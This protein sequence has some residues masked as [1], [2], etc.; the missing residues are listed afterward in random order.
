MKKKVEKP[1]FIPTKAISKSSDG[2]CEDLPEE[3]LLYLRLSHPNICRL[4]VGGDFSSKICLAVKYYRP[5]LP[6]EPEH[7]GFHFI[8][9]LLVRDTLNITCSKITSMAKHHPLRLR[10][11]VWFEQT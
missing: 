6:Q 7:L 11:Y 3:A 1:F 5:P 4:L 8:F 10:A 9:G 2:R